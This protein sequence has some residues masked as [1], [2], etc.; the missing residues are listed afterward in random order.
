MHH[1]PIS[2]RERAHG[3][4]RRQ[5]FRIRDLT[6]H[7]AITGRRP[8]QRPSLRD[9][10]ALLARLHHRTIR[11]FFYFPRQRVQFPG[12]SEAFPVQHRI[13]VRRENIAHPIALLPRRAETIRVLA[14]AIETRPMPCRECS[15]LIE[16]EQLG[17]ALPFHYL[18]ATAAEF[19]HASEP[20]VGGPALPE[21]RLRRR[22]VNDTAIA[23]KHSARCDRYDLA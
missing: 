16:K 1:R 3:R 7:R 17:P 14:P 11:Q 23:D 6:L 19:Q 8:H 4:R 9:Q 22:I 2:G 15:R 21:Q 20:D 12:R 10:K 13:H 18:A 5:K